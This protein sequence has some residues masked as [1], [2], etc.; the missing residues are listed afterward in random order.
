[1]EQ[2]HGDVSGR[3]VFALPHEGIWMLI[4]TEV[5]GGGAYVPRVLRKPDDPKMAGGQRAL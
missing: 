2:S 4:N 1:M 3:F 5:G